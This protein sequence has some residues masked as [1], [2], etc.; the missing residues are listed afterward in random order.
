MRFFAPALAD[1]ERVD[2]DGIVVRLR[3]NGRSRRVSVRIDPRTGEAVAS[4]PSVR[5][6][7]DAVDFARARR[8]WLAARLKARPARQSLAAGS[9]IQVFGEVWMLQPDG[10][11]PRIEGGVLRGCGVGEVDPQL[12]ARAVK[13]AAL[14]RFRRLCEGHCTRLGVALPEISVSDPASRWGSCSPPAR[15]SRGRVR[16]SWRLA[17]AP[18]A[19]ADYVAAHEC[20]HL[21]EANHGPQFWALVR[22]LV[23]DPSTHRAWL[24]R[25][26][27]SLLAFGEPN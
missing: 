10:R 24:R 4:A 15:G 20:C 5:R 18:L 19:T 26:G 3:V 9:R 1:G 2:V 17:L 14:E 7:S 22:K 21:V 16:L 12:L 13:M 27:V 25:H 11:R 23:G 6:L 8:G